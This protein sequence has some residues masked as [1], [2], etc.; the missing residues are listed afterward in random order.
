MTCTQYPSCSRKAVTA[1]FSWPLQE[2]HGDPSYHGQM[3]ESD[4]IR[5][6]EEHGGDCYLTRYSQGNNDY[7]LTVVRNKKNENFKFK[8]DFG[9]EIVGT[10][11]KF[12]DL[13]TLLTHYR[14][15]AISHTFNGIGEHVQ[16]PNFEPPDDESDGIAIVCKINHHR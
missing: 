1:V 6:L 2:F 11:N 3:G 4:A 5:I 7:V 12:N 15:R 16:S 8:T 13:R 10:G 14:K 9:F